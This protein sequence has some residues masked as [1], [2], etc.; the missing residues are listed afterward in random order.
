V[1]VKKDNAPG[2]R[3]VGW[4]GMAAVPGAGGLL[5]PMLFGRFMLFCASRRQ[6][7]TWEPS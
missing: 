2:G 3:W 5:I 4:P 7:N 1:L 6:A